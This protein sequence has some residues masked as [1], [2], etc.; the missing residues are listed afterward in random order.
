MRLGEGS[1][2]WALVLATFSHVS[3][4][5][6]GASGLLKGQLASADV[7]P[8]IDWHIPRQY[9]GLGRIFLFVFKN[10]VNGTR[11]AWFPE[12]MSYHECRD[13]SFATGL[14]LASVGNCY[15]RELTGCFNRTLWDGT[16]NGVSF[17]IPLV[18]GC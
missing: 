2:F 16:V 9:E 3:C 10:W 1:L 12:E 11:Y 15:L 5:K 7:G 4:Q 13:L 18:S 14:D 17:S 6:A 8:F